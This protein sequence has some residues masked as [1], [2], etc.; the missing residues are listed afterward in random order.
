MALRVVQ[1]GERTLKGGAPCLQGAEARLW[2][3]TT[4]QGLRSRWRHTSPGW[5]GQDEPRQRL[6]AG[7]ASCLK[8]LR[9]SVLV[10]GGHRPRP[11]TPIA[12]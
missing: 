3:P 1:A 12:L 11:R 8:P 5:E 2:P 4:E 9:F 6:G 7:S 10:T